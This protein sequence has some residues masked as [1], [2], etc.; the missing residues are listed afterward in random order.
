M[1]E[2]I[3]KIGGEAGFGIMGSGLLFGKVFT[4]TGYYAHVYAEYPSLIKG[5]HNTTQVRISDT[6]TFSPR[7]TNDLVVALNKFAVEAHAPHM[8]S[9]GGIIYDSKDSGIEGLKIPPGIQLYD[10]P[11]LELAQKAGG[12]MLMRNTVAMGA[13]L[14]L[15]GYPL[16]YFNTI[17]KEMF[18]RKGGEIVD[19]NINAAKN[20]Y[21]YIM[22][23]YD[24]SKFPHKLRP[25]EGAVR[26]LVMTGNEAISAGAIQAG[27][28]FF[29]A[30]PMTPASS[31]LHY[32]ASK[33]L[34]HNI[35]VKH[36]EDEIAAMN[37]AIGASFAGVRSMT[38]TSGGGF[39]LKVEALGM[40]AMSETPVVVVLSQ[41][42]G[43]ST[44]MPTW[45]EQAD[46]RFAIHASQG[47]FLRVV[48]APGDVAEAYNLT[49][50]A[51]NIAEKYQLP[52]IIL[53][54]KF[55]SESYS[56]A[57]STE[58][59]KIPIER[60]KIITEDMKP[61]PPQEKFKRYEITAD[62]V[63]PRPFPGVVGGEHISS[64]Y[65]HWE[66]T[67]STEHFE[68]RKKMV[69][70]RARKIALLEKELGTPTQHGPSDAQ[71]TLVCWGSQ[72]HVVFEAVDIL[73]AEGKS[74][75]ALHFAYVHPLPRK[76]ISMLK[77]A[78][79]LVIVENNSTAQF[80]GYLKEHAGVSF[81]GSILRYDGRQ[82]FPENVCSGVR[83]ILE[84]KEKDVQVV[85]KEPVE[86]YTA[87]FVR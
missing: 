12:D 30:Y 75:N 77:A 70:K 17:I 51:F 42:T 3:W 49:Q 63:S 58:L 11:L 6:H 50:K 14:A 21:D 82:L 55:L 45:T 83:M 62:G 31:I 29:A 37:M 4:R 48:L 36:C 38:S 81:V 28:K 73:N 69:D 64:S 5:G 67:F 13:S 16:D 20:G 78:K 87:S 76:A 68:T 65:E 46:L 7:L 44:G 59:Q 66:N 35:V 47:D 41:R 27:V 1:A 40:A 80:G 23:N 53:S 18:G 84:G 9:N 72:K 26:K 34:E 57:D 52:V 85:D 39:S 19:I 74:V 86:F 79:K 10:V 71:I 60:G 8:S 24:V 25:R 56:T 43:P 54:D 33:E 32:M 22:Q 15:L 61:L 2:F